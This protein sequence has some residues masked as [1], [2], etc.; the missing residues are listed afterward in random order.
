MEVVRMTGRFELDVV[1]NWQ[2]FVEIVH[3]YDMGPPHQPI[4]LFRGHADSNWPLVPSLIRMAR[5]SDLKSEHV[6]ALENH[7]L[8]EFMKQAHL[9]LTPQTIPDKGDL[10]SWWTLMQHHHA[11]TRLLDWTYSPF[12]ALYFACEQLDQLEGAVWMV[13]S[14]RI[15]DLMVEKFPDCAGHA[16]KARQKQYYQS[17]SGP[18]FLE[19]I[20]RNTQTAQMVAQQTMHSVSPAPLADHGELV[21]S[22]LSG[23]ESGAGN[24]FRKLIIPPQQKIEFLRTLRFMNVTSNALFPGVDG[25]GRSI[26]ELA[27]LS[28]GH[29]RTQITAEKLYGGNS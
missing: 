24:P 6:S 16:T 22:V 23:K 9:H 14:R 10:L 2:H 27:L 7:L 20:E 25:L 19:F 29:F 5:R 17:P 28:C 21:R 11:P 26:A 3:M 1:K 4:F 18:D 8:Q 12:V 15:S 13:A